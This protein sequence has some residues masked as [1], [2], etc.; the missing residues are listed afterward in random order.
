MQFHIKR[1]TANHND[2]QL[3]VKQLDFEL[4]VELKEDQAT[5]DQHNKVPDIETALVAYEANEPVACGCFKSFSTDTV[6]IKRMFVRKDKRGKGI[7]KRI[8]AEL[9][10][11]AKEK[12]YKYAVLETSKYFD[13]ALNLYS[14]Q[15]YRQ[16]PNYGPYVNLPDSVCMKKELK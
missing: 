9:E 15:G 3:L 7:S 8:L 2:F 12:D 11:W 5:Y 1:T 10:G 4:W 6:E 14:S 13:T 16:I